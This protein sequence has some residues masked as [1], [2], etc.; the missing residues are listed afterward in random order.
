MEPYIEMG[1]F[2]GKPRIFLFTDWE[3]GISQKCKSVVG[4]RW[5]PDYEHK[6]W[7]Y[8]LRM[9]T[10]HALR[11][12]WGDG[13]V[14]GQKLTAW[15]RAEAA[16]YKE[17]RELAKLPD[18]PLER[19][20]ELYP[21]IWEAMSRRTYQRSGADFLGRLLTAADFDEP[22]LG[23]TLTAIAAI[24]QAGKWDGKHLV[25]CPK[26]AIFSTWVHELE[27]WTDARVYAMPDGFAAR[28][29]VLMDFLEDEEPGARFL[30]VH[31]NMIQIKLGKLCKKCKIWVGKDDF[32]DEHWEDNHKPTS[33][34]QK[35]DWPELFDKHIWDSVIADECQNY[36]LKLR[37]AA[38]RKPES[39]PQWAHGMRGLI[40]ATK[41]DGLRI[42][43]TGTPFR[44]KEENLFGILHWIDPVKHSSFWN[45]AGAFLEVDEETHD[46]WGGGTGSHKVVGHIAPGREKAFYD[47]LDSV[48]LRRTKAEV[49]AD[50]PP[51]DQ[52]E[53]WVEM[54]GE[55][56]KQYQDF[57]GKGIAE[58][59]D[60]VIE[61]I[62]VLQELT[63]LRQFSFGPWN[64]EYVA[65]PDGSLKMVMKPI[66][67]KSPKVALLID[68][69]QQRGIMGE[70]QSGD[71]KVVVASQWT[72][73]LDGM[74]G[75]FA[76]MN[77]PTLKI[78]GKVTGRK[79]TLAAN[80][81]RKKGGARI[82]LL[83]TK[84]GGTSLTLDEY[85]DDLF[86]MDE[87]WIH[88]D[89]VQV[90]GRIDNRGQDIRPRTTHYIRTMG[91][92]EEGISLKNTDQ[93]NMQ[94][95]ILDGRRGVKTALSLLRR[96][97]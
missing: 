86:L 72:S 97:A 31:P 24:I 19:V 9:Q 11:G 44:G 34:I 32:P 92:V 46:E 8:P 47:M 79:R 69:L 70:F 42:P 53:H 82:M 35:C 26:T 80:S 74:E 21:A 88:D 90:M 93:K 50:L 55:H 94:E 40:Q 76:D 10:C 59:E 16:Q 96:E 43:M 13:M 2:E 61:K 71:R 33:A 3:P 45:W 73:I 65:R 27:K 25:M 83:Q 52:Q 22:G 5:H 81:F 18:S 95:Q 62:G 63:R 4:N 17:I 39:Q 67:D 85:C 29:E 54:S 49:R 48:A 30:I 1:E 78:T 41:P 77:A 23:K 57:E 36:L 20:R 7:S 66:V 12:V 28:E 75:M 84:A 87:T 64:V 15:A 56:K 91:T 38:G 6:P 60:G 89:Q 51:M 58:L 14:I 68:M 37:P